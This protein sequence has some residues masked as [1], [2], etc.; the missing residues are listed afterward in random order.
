MGRFGDFVGAVGPAVKKIAGSI[1]DEVSTALF[2]DFVEEMEC[3][4]RKAL[5]VP[6]DKPIVKPLKNLFKVYLAGEAGEDDRETTRD[7]I[8]EEARDDVLA[9]DAAEIERDIINEE[10]GT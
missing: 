10:E 8:E 7:I 3:K 4:I 1:K 2:N 9:D 5:C 6:A